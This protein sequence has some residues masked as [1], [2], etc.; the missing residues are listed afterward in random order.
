MNS[1]RA[2][3]NGR[4]TCTASLLASKSSKASQEI[5]QCFALARLQEDRATIAGLQS[6]VAKLEATQPVP[7]EDFTFFN[8]ANTETEPITSPAVN[9]SRYKQITFSEWNAGGIAWL[10]EVGPDETWVG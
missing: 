1:K 8:E 9:A 5:A 7:P 3:T 6:A 10:E 2:P 4:A